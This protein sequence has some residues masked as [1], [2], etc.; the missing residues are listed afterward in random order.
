MNLLKTSII[1]PSLALLLSTNLFAQENY[2]IQNKTLTE[3]LEIISKKANIPYI[4][5]ESLLKGKKAPILENVNGI[6][7]A[8]SKI[9]K[10]TNLEAIIK[11]GTIIIKKKVTKE[12]ESSSSLGEVEVIE[13]T[14]NNTE[15]INSYTI[16]STNT[17]TKLDL[18]LKD[19]PQSIVV[20]TN[21]ELKDKNIQTFQD[22]TSSV[23]GF[24]S[25]TW[26]SDRIYISARGF[27]VDYYQLDGIPTTYDGDATDQNL[28]MYDRVEIVKG[29]NGLA[30]GAGNPAASINMIRKHANSRKFEGE[31]TLT[32]GS[33]NERSA[34]I[35][36]SIPLSQD[37]RVRSRIVA[38][39]TNKESFRDF[40]SKKQDTFYGIIDADLS[41]QTKIS[42][43][44]SY[45][46]SK[47]KGSS[48]GG[49]PV[50]FNDNSFT[51]FNN[52]TAFVPKWSSYDKKTTSIFS[53][54][55]HIFTNDIKINANYSY[56]EVMASPKMTNF[57]GYP[58]KG[59]GLGLNM[60]WGIL[61]DKNK[62]K[63][64]VLDLYSSI[65]FELGKQEHEIIIGAMYNNNKRSSSSFWEDN[66][67]PA[68]SV[69][70]WN[71]NI[72]EPTYTLNSK[73]N[74]SAKESAVYVVGRFNLLDDLKLIT[75]ARISNYKFD[76]NGW[77]T[78][79]S[80]KIEKTITPYAGLV[81]NIDENHSAYVSYTNIFKPQQNKDINNKILD[82]KTGNNY[83][84]GVKAEYLDK[85]LN[86]SLTY[87]IIQ[88]NNVAE[89]TGNIIPGTNENAYRSVDGVKSKGIE[90]SVKG[91]ITDNWNVD[92]ALY[93][94]SKKDQK[95]KEL[96]TLTPKR[97]MSLF[98][99]Y[100]LDKLS[101][102]GGISW[103]DDIHTNV[104]NYSGDE[105]KVTQEDFYLVNIM[106]KYDFTKDLSFQ[107]NINN[108]FNKEYYS[109]ITY[110]SYGGG[111]V[112]GDPR[113]I[114]G[115]VNYKF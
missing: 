68:Q 25:P 26:D 55:E 101:F 62:I 88:Q 94:F 115:Q 77:G 109:N 33:W 4:A 65:P 23:V 48:W 11:N 34:T 8:L 80:Y 91:E 56:N 89:E 22:L 72:Q 106:G 27:E 45:I 28:I 43:G 39:K 42:F 38:Q 95:G 57:G 66:T 31:A 16:T 82:P 71:G 76:S 81:Y 108:L 98:S 58:D 85:R 2:T 50:F 37:G 70:S 7:N 112:F 40:Y 73:N 1:A 78:P 36:L 99:K 24:H 97:E 83:E 52:S 18:S 53:N 79:A 84:I 60:S 15:G 44:A 87:F 21:Q 96:S 111:Y 64:Q 114:S 69:Y 113:K 6:K 59:T 41:D 51:N 67:V 54:F 103:Q 5:E 107:I 110:G 90:L 86:T 19:T 63:N 104:T 17:A 13:R 35:D 20:V 47:I 29:A 61:N 10:N 46:K 100:K 12:E 102:G 9:L 14:G 32:A 75:G 74:M 30:S 105:I 49:L 92:F 93:N 3:A